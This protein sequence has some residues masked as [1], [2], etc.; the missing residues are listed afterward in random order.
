M[1][2][3]ALALTFLLFSLP[4]VAQHAPSVDDVTTQYLAE[5]GQ[6]RMELARARADN[7]ALKKQLEE[8]KKAKEPGKK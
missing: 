3:L 4:A 8:A 7:A 2:K 5:T 6:L 1:K